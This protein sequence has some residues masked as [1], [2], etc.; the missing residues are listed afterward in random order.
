MAEPLTHRPPRELVLT[1][2][3]A[4]SAELAHTSALLEDVREGLLA[5]G[6]PARAAAFTSEARGEDVVRF[7]SAQEVDLLLTDAP[8]QLL[9]DGSLPGGLAVI[10]RE[11]PCDVAVVVPG[12]G[13]LGAGPGQDVVVPF[14]GTEHDWAALEMG[15]WFA[16]SQGGSMTLLGRDARP[17]DGKRDASRMLAAVS[18]IAQRSTGVA[19]KPQLIAPGGDAILEASVD[20][21]LLILGLSERWADEG[22]GHLRLALARDARP[23]TLI[24]R[25]GVRPGGIAP[26]DGLT[27]YTWSL[28]DSGDS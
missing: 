26:P 17:A 22:L 2:I 4:T 27:R 16:A 13:R 6:V 25:S 24:V 14:G 20:A 18:L 9:A 7:A 21:G 8:A 23:P 1:A 10:F 11:A 12:D 15:A 28:A 3:A 5:R 19:A